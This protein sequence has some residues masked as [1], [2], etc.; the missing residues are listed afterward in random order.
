MVRIA[1]PIPHIKELTIPTVF[2]D[3]GQTIMMFGTG[4]ITAIVQGDLKR[5]EPFLSIPIK[6]DPNTIAE[7][8][9]DY[10][11]LGKI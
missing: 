9:N 6:C 10:S 8:M 2:P 1:R 3:V 5:K 7:M 4:K 11:G